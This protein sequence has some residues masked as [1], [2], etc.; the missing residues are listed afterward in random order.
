MNST[1]S[2]KSIKLVVKIL[3]SCSIY[4]LSFSSHA[5]AQMYEELSRSTASQMRSQISDSAPTISSFSSEQEKQKWIAQKSVRLA[6]FLAPSEYSSILLQSIHY[7][8]TR[9]GLEPELVLGLIEVESG[10]KKYAISSVGARGY[11]QVMPFW[12]NL[13]S[14]GHNHN[15]FSLRTNLRYGCVILRHYLDIEK[16]NMIRSL[17]RYNGSLGKTHYSQAVLAARLKWLSE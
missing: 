5:G 8:A 10:F 16:G 17:A 1:A 2:I 14:G 12:L 3:L 15:L 9:A 7:E 11:M 13:L 6:R 4:A